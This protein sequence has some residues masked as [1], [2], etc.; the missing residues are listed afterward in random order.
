MQGADCKHAYPLK[1][2]QDGDTILH[3]L[4]SHSGMTLVQRIGQKSQT[5]FLRNPEDAVVSPCVLWVR[6]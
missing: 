4:P 6:E 2:S 1:S 5:V 3:F